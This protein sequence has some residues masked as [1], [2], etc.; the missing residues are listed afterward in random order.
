MA[1]QKTTATANGP[2]LTDPFK[3][4]ASLFDA[5]LTRIDNAQATLQRAQQECGSDCPE[6]F[7]LEDVLSAMGMLAD[8]GLVVNG[9]RNSVRQADSLGW[10]IKD[11]SATY[12]A[13]ARATAQHQA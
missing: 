11:E 8:S 9:A 1:T 3:V 4:S 10:L 7:A 13:A 12:I 2:V 5:I 6:L